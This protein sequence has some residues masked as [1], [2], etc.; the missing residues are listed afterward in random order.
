[1]LPL[2]SAAIIEKNKLESDGVWIL[3]LEITLVDGT[4]LRVCRNTEDIEWNGETW[5]AFPF[6]LDIVGETSK[7][8][9]PQVVVKVSNVT[10]Q[11]Q[12]YLE[13]GEGGVGA[14][15]RIMYVHSKHLYLPNP[16][17]ELVYEVIASNADD[18]WVTF[19]LG[20][21][22][23]FNKNFPRH[24]VLRNFCRWNFKDENCQYQGDA[25]DCNKTLARCRQL[26]NSHRFGSYPSVGI[27]ALYV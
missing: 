14:Q 19:T 2:S 7:G 4:I 17:I 1:M 23:P 9:V 10:R 22:N 3:L 15:V 21:E 6:E 26:G 20:A 16:E 11:I 25:I 13:Q 18:K 27:G 8:E 24:R 5:V 12:Y